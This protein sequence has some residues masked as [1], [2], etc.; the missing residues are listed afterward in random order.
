VLKVDIFINLS[1]VRSHILVNVHVQFL[2]QL[3]LVMM[4]TFAWRILLIHTLMETISMEVEWKCAIM[5]PIVLCVM[6]V[7]P[8]VMLPS[9][10]TTLVTAI[11]TIVS[12]IY[13][14]LIIFKLIHQQVPRLL[15]ERYLVYQM[16]P[17]YFR[18]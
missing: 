4:E 15:E 3:H 6:R 9:S 10:V 14:L 16:K 2:H 18:T 7:G 12:G 8:T 1:S 17:P 13:E 5:A 11:H